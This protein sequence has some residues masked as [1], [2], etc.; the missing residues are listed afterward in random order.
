MSEK[1]VKDIIGHE[2][3]EDVWFIA[4]SAEPM[5]LDI[6]YS[7]HTV[8]GTNTTY[9]FISIPVKGRIV[10]FYVTKRKLAY[11]NPIKGKSISVP[12]LYNIGG[13]RFS[14]N[15]SDELRRYYDP[16]TDSL[17]FEIEVEF[18]PGAI[19]HNRPFPNTFYSYSM[20]LNDTSEYFARGLVSISYNLVGDTPEEAIEK[21]VDQYH[22]IKFFFKPGKYPIRI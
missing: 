4:S 7:D 11:N 18:S 21:F 15:N 3:G 10:S 8:N 9:R 14:E 17:T 2:I 13:T 1:T 6:E 12:R 5:K 22:D 16:R 19:D 20:Y